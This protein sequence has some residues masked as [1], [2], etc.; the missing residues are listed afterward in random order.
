MTFLHPW[1]LILLLALPAAYRALIGAERRRRTQLE[2]FGEPAVLARSSVLPQE[3]VRLRRIRIR[4]VALALLVTALARPQLGEQPDVRPHSGRDLLVLLDISRSMGSPDVSPSRMAAAKAAAEELVARLPG[5]RVGLIVFGGSA[6]LQLPLVR[7]HA[8]FKLFLD[9]ASNQYLYDPSTDIATAL[10]TAVAV[11]DHEGSHGS[12]AIILVSDGESQP[13]A[14]VD[15]TP[16][17]QQER[18]PVFAIGVGTPEG[19]PVPAD[20][21]EAP[22]RWHRDHIGRVVNSRLEEAG[23][24]RLAR[25]TGGDYLRW[26]DGAGLG[27]MVER[28]RQ[29]EVRVLES[30]GAESERADRFQWP[31]AAGLLLLL[32]EFFLGAWP[33]RSS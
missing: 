19:G 24:I 11:F 27:P 22:E 29:V 18:I 32:A 21:S 33:A 15:V 9:A 17:L 16:V 12:R 2:E 13:E 26:K 28:I 3:A 23:L 25:E 8:A 5:D 14:M 1:V 4:L 6:F 20:S 30:A 7:D 31:L 10:R